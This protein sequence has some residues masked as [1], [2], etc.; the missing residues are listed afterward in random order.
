MVLKC[1]KFFHALGLKEL[2]IP[3]VTFW[4][5]FSSLDFPWLILP[6]CSSVRAQKSPPQRSLLWLPQNT[7]PLQ[8]SLPQYFVY[9][10]HNTYY[11]LKLPCAF[12]CIPAYCLALPHKWEYRLLWEVIRTG[13]SIWYYLNKHEHVLVNLWITSMIYGITYSW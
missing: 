5:T 6:Q 9:F 11:H 4:I 13:P 12:I 7:T 10:H 3:W 1:S 8:L 2:A